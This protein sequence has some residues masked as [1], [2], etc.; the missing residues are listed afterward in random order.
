MSRPTRL[1][2]IAVAALTLLHLVYYGPRVVDDLFISLRYGENLIHGRGLVYNVGERVEGFSSP[3]WAL[4]QSIG[5]ALRIE[6]VLWTKLLGLGSLALLHV[7]LFRF[8]R[9]V[10]QLKTFAVW[11]PNFFLALNSYVIAW[12]TLGLETPL[13]VALIVWSFVLLG[14]P[15]DHRRAAAVLVVLAATRP[16]GLA[17]ALVALASAVASEPLKGM[18]ARVVELRRVAIPFALSVIALLLLRRLYYGSWVPHTYYAKAA[19]TP[20]ELA[21]LRGLTTN[22]RGAET[23]LTAGGVIAI[24]ISTHENRKRIAGLAIAAMTAFFVCSVEVDWMPSFRHFLPMIVVAPVGFAW[25]VETS[26]ER[27]SVVF[28]M[29]AAVAIAIALLGI[30]TIAR[31]DLRSLGA[32]FP[33][34]EHASDKTRAKLAD[35]WLSLRNIEPPHVAAMH[36]FAMGMISQNYRILEASSA[37]LADSWYVGRDIGK[38]GYYTG[39]KVFETAGLFT[40][41]V[42]RDARWRKERIPSDALLDQALAL[43]PVA[44]EWFEWAFWAARNPTRLRAF[45]I[46]GGSPEVPMQLDARI[47]GPDPN[48]ILRRYEESLAKFP[49]TFL[50]STLHGESVGGAMARRTRI[51]RAAVAELNAMPSPPPDGALPVGNLDDDA[52]MSRGCTFDPP[53]VKPGGET[54]FRCWFDVVKTTGRPWIFFVH[55]L[56]ANGAVHLAADHPPSGDIQ[57]SMKWHTGTRVRDHVRIK[58][59]GTFRVGVYSARIGLYWGNQRATVTGASAVEGNALMGPTLEVA[60]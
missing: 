47:P 17:W 29:A 23:A 18:R 30:V 20:F 54:T 34:G 28:R 19:N 57:P 53:R 37:P 8:C 15:H 22:V 5:L 38:V 33:S 45:G 11:L 60:P 42:V 13:F 58:I 44:I 52:V 1:L 26:R 16:E 4:L 36:P 31:T 2:A 55:L 41:A 48:E 9:D 59:P 51:V 6:G 24:A 40:P 21:H 10:F 56:D 35:A 12:S 43:R 32:P 27:T 49:H 46:A 7:G 3:S 25:L 14:A 50:L 39:V